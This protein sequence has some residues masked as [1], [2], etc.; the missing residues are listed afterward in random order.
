MQKKEKKR[1]GKEA[2][3]GQLLIIDEYLWSLHTYRKTTLCLENLY[4]ILRKQ[5]FK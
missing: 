3:Y 5:T 2:S 4:F 1:K